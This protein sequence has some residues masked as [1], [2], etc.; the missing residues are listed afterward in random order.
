M[1]RI[2]HLLLPELAFAVVGKRWKPLLNATKETC[3]YPDDHAAALYAG[4]DGTWRKYFTP[5]K[6]RPGP[7]SAGQSLAKYLPPIRFYIRKIISL[8]KSKNDKEAAAYLGVFSHLLGDFSQPAHWYECEIFD[9]LPP[10]QELGTCNLHSRI[11]NICSSLKRISHKPRLTG[12]SADELEFKLKGRFAELRSLA[13]AAIIPM[14]ENLYAGKI[15]KAREHYNPVMEKA[16]QI[17]ADF[18]YT[19]EAIAGKRFRTKDMEA[20][21]KCSLLE[22]NPDSYDVEGLYGTRPFSG[23]FTP[24]AAEQPLPLSLRLAGRT[25]K[26]DGICAVPYALPN[27]NRPF[28]SWMEFRL[29]PNI[30]RRFQAS[31]GL[32]AGIEP[33]AKC[34]FE[35]SGDDRNIYSSEVMTPGSEAIHLDLNINDVSRLKLI[36]YTDGSTDKLAYPVWMTPTLLK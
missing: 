26:V 36:V 24:S 28:W 34:H 17:L 31:I 1:N 32:C 6:H 8:L 16:A 27:G 13:V 5:G 4:K 21:I 25:K 15:E 3:M 7:K 20:C 19:V 2:D 35:V 18:I 9:L 14:L 12:S 30:Y 33:Q 29:P 22:L 11:E 10:P 23:Y